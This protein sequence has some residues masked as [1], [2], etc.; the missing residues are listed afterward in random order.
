MKNEVHEVLKN[1]IQELVIPF[2]L[3][4]NASTEKLK[5]IHNLIYVGR[6]H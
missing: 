2:T 6:V 3:D 5:A 4:F 1:V